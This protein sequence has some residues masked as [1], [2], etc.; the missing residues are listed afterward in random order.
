MVSDYLTS[1]KDLGSISEQTQGDF[2]P[3]EEER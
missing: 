2:L 3:E 1:S